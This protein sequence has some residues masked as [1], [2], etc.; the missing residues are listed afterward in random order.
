VGR[1]AACAAEEP[2][3]LEE[4]SGVAVNLEG[5][6]PDKA[7][8]VKDVRIP[9]RDGSWLA[10]DL[11]M[12]PTPGQYGAVMEFL[13]YRKD[14]LT[15]THLWAHRYFASRGYVGARIDARGTGASP[16]HSLDEYSAQEQEDAYDACEWLAA[17]EWCSGAVGAFGIS[18]GGY[19]SC[20]LAVSRPPHLRAIAPMHGFDDR[21]TDDCHYDGGQL[22]TYDI[23]R[24]GTRMLATN[25][26]PPDPQSA[27]PSW[28]E[29]WRERLQRSEPWLLQWLRH[30]T[31]GPYWRQGSI[32]DRV[33]EIECAVLLWGGWQDGYIN[34]IFRM[35][36]RLRAPKRAI[37]GPWMH[38]RPDVGP[39]GPLV[40]WLRETCRWWDQ[41]LGGIDTGVMQQAPVVL[42]MQ[43][44][45]VPTSGR[46]Y[47]SGYWREESS[48]PAP[49][50]SMRS[51]Y[52][53][54][55][56]R[57]GAERPTAREA[58][59][60]RYRPSAG[61]TAGEFS[62][63]GLPDFGLPLD[64][65][66]D[67]AYCLVYLGEAITDPIEIVGQPLVDLHAS[68]S[69]EAVVF[70]ARLCDVAPDGSVAMVTKGVLN[71]TRRESMSEPEPLVPGEVYHLQIHLRATAWRFD[72]GHR[73]VLVVSNGEF[74]R[75]WPSPDLAVS[76]IWRGGEDSSSLCLPVVPTGQA[77]AGSPPLPELDRLAA[78][79]AMDGSY[80][81]VQH[82]L[83][84][85]SVE[86]RAGFV[87]QMQVDAGTEVTDRRELTTRVCNND[88][89]SAHAAGHTVIELRR[90]D[91]VTSVDAHSDVTGSRDALHV[92]ETLR[93]TLNGEE[94]FTRTW[95]ESIPRQLL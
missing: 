13:P 88:P 36:P 43:S 62:A 32:R 15:G 94:F 54:D 39:P 21:Y 24:Y 77:A 49:A 45:D 35:F 25:A 63:G 61:L 52:L 46:R 3:T 48:L 72:V 66:G 31:D 26:L 78:G 87:K 67:L 20:Q 70:A 8:I 23:G 95:S 7:R 89:A 28:T 37:I 82:D 33:Q 5:A 73:I 38:A 84:T 93:V 12:P 4:D 90:R 58:D 55:G 80:Q 64:Q 91:F 81:S 75:L 40:D 59:E 1:G 2:G 41:W 65:R 10:A 56:R 71:A 47:T 6:D 69:T 34:P 74:P 17:Q 85:D 92:L 16:G 14:D 86:V 57:L 29:M 51:L 50:G 22:Q 18:Y 53:G 30:Q 60:L 27:G 9:M 68:T 19:T 11:V 76:S 44:Y 83:L 42:Y 79:G